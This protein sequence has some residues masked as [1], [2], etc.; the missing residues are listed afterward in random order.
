MAGEPVVILGGFL[1]TPRT[2]WEMQ[3]ALEKLAG[4]TVRIVPVTRP[5]WALSV[6]AFGWGRILAK[7]DRTVRRVLLETGAEEAVIVGHSSGGVVARLYL[8]PEPFRGRVWDGRRSVRCLV[9]LGSPNRNYRGSAMR[10]RVD[11]TYPG[12]FFA[13]AVRYVTVAGK[14]VL[15][16]RGGRAGE[17]A[18]FRSYRLLCGEGGVWGD[19]TVPLPS[20]LLDGAVPVVLEGVHHYSR[21][22]RPWYGTTRVVGRWW[23]AVRAA[24]EE[25]EPAADAIS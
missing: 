21:G 19:G 17:R 23:E 9:T 8:G 22:G 18:A 13:P 3:P 11:R 5:D 15:G 2:Y 1:S 10:R 4:R 14:A 24:L 6:W 20:A 12:A 25:A 16:D 7:L